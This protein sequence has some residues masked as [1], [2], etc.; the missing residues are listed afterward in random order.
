MNGNPF[1][2]ILEMEKEKRDREGES[3]SKRKNAL[4]THTRHLNQPND[5]KV[6]FVYI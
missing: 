3:E 2:T 4:Y 5:L 6:Q 1:A